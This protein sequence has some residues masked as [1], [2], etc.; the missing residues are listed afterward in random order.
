MTK[1]K[2]VVENLL[3]FAGVKINGSD[4]W[5]IKV[6]NERLYSRILGQ[7]SLGLGEA[8]MDGWWDCESLDQFFDRVLKSNL[9]EKIKFNWLTMSVTPS[10]NF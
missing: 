7:G 4:P 6:N 1:E 5:D 9:K 10:Q 2:K 8:Y 3:S